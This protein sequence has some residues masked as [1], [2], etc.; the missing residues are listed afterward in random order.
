MRFW[1][2]CALI[3]ADETFS[4]YLRALGDSNSTHLRDLWCDRVRLQLR[5]IALLLP[6][7][8]VVRVGSRANISLLGMFST[9]TGFVS[10]Q[11]LRCAVGVHTAAQIRCACAVVRADLHRDVLRWNRRLAD[12]DRH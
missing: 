7:V 2:R 3:Q 9:S 1:E 11:I 8:T 12:S 6:A 4:G 10:F 5:G